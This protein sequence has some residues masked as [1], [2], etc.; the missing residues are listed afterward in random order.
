[1]KHNVQVDASVHLAV[2]MQDD[3]PPRIRVSVTVPYG[4]RGRNV[5]VMQDIEAPEGLDTQ[6][7]DIMDQQGK[8]LLPK[9]MNAAN[10]ALELASRRREDV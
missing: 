6:L 8:A 7:R 4:S 1:M 9:A 3:A 5:T 10:E 2:K